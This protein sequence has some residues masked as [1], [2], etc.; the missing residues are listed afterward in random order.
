MHG[1]MKRDIREMM[2]GEGIDTRRPNREGV[3]R[4]SE[5]GQEGFRRGS[6]GGGEGACPLRRARCD[7]HSRAVHIGLRVET[8]GQ[9]GGRRQPSNLFSRSIIKCFTALHPPVETSEHESVRG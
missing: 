8:N 9:L 6:G 4:G 2:R 5:R 3:G 7:E 1:M